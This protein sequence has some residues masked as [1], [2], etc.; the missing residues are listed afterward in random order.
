M[1]KIKNIT[2]RCFLLFMTVMLSCT[3]FLSRSFAVP[4]FP[5]LK[6]L[7]NRDGSTVKGYIRGDEYF[8]YNLDKE[9]RI[10]QKDEKND[11]CWKYVYNISGKLS[12]GGKAGESVDKSK[13]LKEEE[14]KSQSIRKQYY[15]LAGK[16][17]KVTKKKKEELIDLDSLQ[18]GS[19][20]FRMMR[21]MSAPKSI[22]LLTI[23]VGFNDISYDN[24]VNWGS[25]LSAGVGEYYMEVSKNQFTFSP[26]KETSA[27][28]KDGNTNTEDKANDGV[29]HINLNRNHGSWGG[30]DTPDVQTD[31]VLTLKDAIK[32]AEPYVDFSSFDKDGDG[33][34]SNDEMAVLFIIAGYESAFSGSNTHGVW[35][36]KAE[37]QSFNVD[38]VTLDKYIAQGEL[39]E[40]KPNGSGADAPYY[41]SVSTPCHE[42]GH[43]IGLPDLYNIEYNSGPWEKYEVGSLSLMANGSWGYKENASN[44]RTEYGATHLDPYCKLILGFEKA[45][46]ISESGEYTVNS[47]GSSEGYNVY[48]VRTNRPNEYFLIENRQYEKADENLKGIYKPDGN[49]AGGIVVWHIDNDIIEEYGVQNSFSNKYNR[50]NTADHV[51]GVM[52][53]YYVNNGKVEI[54]RP[55]WNASQKATFANSK[56][57]TG[58]YKSTPSAWEASGVSIISS[59]NGSSSMKVEVTL[60]EAEITDIIFDKPELPKAGGPI[61][62]EVNGKNFYKDITVQVFD[63]TGQPVNG[64]WA[65]K[66]IMAEEDILSGASQSMTKRECEIN[67]PDNTSNPLKTYVI[68]VSADGGASYLDFSKEM[69]VEGNTYKNR[70]LT[71]KNTNISVEGL[72]HDTAALT[73]A[74]INEEIKARLSAQL[75]ENHNYIA[76]YDLSVTSENNL[77]YKGDLKV[78]FPIGESFNGKELVVVHETEQGTEVLNAAAENGFINVQVSTLSPFGIYENTDSSN[79]GESKDETEVNGSTVGGNTNNEGGNNNG[80]GEGDTSNNQTG[81]LNNGGQSN[82]KNDV[83]AVVDKL[84]KSKSAVSGNG[85]AAKVVTGDESKVMWIVFSMAVSGILVLVLFISIKKYKIKS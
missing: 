79:Q 31:W 70:I 76:G 81:I 26:A 56:I 20:K 34:I 22:P 8:S 52:P 46:E 50:I 60:P 55:F 73:V 19:S 57:N 84:A 38:G 42:L 59:E 17:Y 61:N 25:M 75:L 35:A 74:D 27:S 12:F 36:H 69:A 47:V 37:T 39:L 33:I 62:V 15:A 83:V 13:L 78:S 29:V 2:A 3:V 14:L 49:A 30:M 7:E 44:G 40:G 41:N 65:K 21:S 80:T 1:R 71:D 64:D 6:E 18:N 4:A 67:F 51:P 28:G 72:Y 43:Y 24:K 5:G 48:A 58:L 66:T 82:D 9:K 54:Q 32:A 23:V 10:I 16:T 77:P 85:N 11:G 68:K 45:V 53:V 63:E